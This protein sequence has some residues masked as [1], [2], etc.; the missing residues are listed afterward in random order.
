MPGNAVLAMDDACTPIPTPLPVTPFTPPTHSQTRHLGELASQP[1]KPCC[2]SPALRNGYRSQ[3]QH[4]CRCAPQGPRPPAGGPSTPR[5]LCRQTPLPA[6]SGT[7]HAAV[8]S[9]ATADSAGQDAHTASKAEAREHPGQCLT[10]R[11][12][13]R[14][15]EPQTR[16]GPA[17]SQLPPARTGACVCC[18][19]GRRHVT[20]PH[21]VPLSAVLGTPWR[22]PACVTRCAPSPQLA[23]ALLDCTSAFY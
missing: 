4:V 14:L 16:P 15:R 3:A 7:G 19:E 6:L 2:H 13:E 8:R 21:S 1:C 12:W 23:P 9:P 17:R 5:V 11:K 18:P 10:S 20:S 22:S